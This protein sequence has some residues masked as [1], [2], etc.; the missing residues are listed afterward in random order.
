M[1]LAAGKSRRLIAST[2][3]GTLNQEKWLPLHLI[4]GGLI[5][6]FELD[7]ADTAFNETG[8]SYE[9]TDVKIFATLHTI[10]SA[11]ANSYASHV[12]K[13]NP[14]HLHYSSVVSS[15]HLVNGSSFTISLVR[16]FTRLK[17][18]FIVFVKNGDKKTKTFSAPLVERITQTRMILLGKFPSVRTA[19]LRD[20]VGGSQNHL[21][22]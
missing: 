1:Q 21:C 12:L 17:Q 6:E 10:D 13:G 4:S 7:D 9:I 5:L 16:G 11:L 18:C 22:V 3:F 2:P 15:R 20:P 19:G 14:L 8:V